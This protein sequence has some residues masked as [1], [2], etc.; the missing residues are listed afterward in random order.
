MTIGFE[1]FLIA[2]ENSD[3]GADAGLLQIYGGEVALL[4]IF[5]GD[6]EFFVEFGEELAAGGGW[7]VGGEGTA[8]EGDRGS[9]GVR[10][11]SNGAIR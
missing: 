1:D 6:R 7:G 3:A 11:S 10:I 9:Q 8:D 4:E 2:G 5:D